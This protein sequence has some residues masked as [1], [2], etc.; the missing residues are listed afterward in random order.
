MIWMKRVLSLVM[1]L[2]LLCLSGCGGNEPVSFGNLDP[3]TTA[4][5]TYAETTVSSEEGT[6]QAVTTSS[7]SKNNGTTTAKPTKTTA[8]TRPTSSDE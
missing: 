5:E 2:L 7:K 6:K 8:T 3:A 4:P 1:A